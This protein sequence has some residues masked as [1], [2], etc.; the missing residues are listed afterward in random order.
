MMKVAKL[1]YLG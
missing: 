1:T